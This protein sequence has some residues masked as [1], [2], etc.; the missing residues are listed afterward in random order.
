MNVVL[1]EKR[2]RDEDGNTYGVERA[3]NGMFVVIRTNSGGN[4]KGVRN[5]RAKSDFHAQC[6]SLDAYAAQKGW[7]S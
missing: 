3:S 2:Y 5:I 1:N 7:I 4:R 6:R